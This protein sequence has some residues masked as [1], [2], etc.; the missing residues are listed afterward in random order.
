ML[1]LLVEGGF[2]EI[3]SSLRRSCAFQS[4]TSNKLIECRDSVE[5]IN[6]FEPSGA[7]NG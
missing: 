6:V 4:N 5:G 3:S 7:S 1:S 2:R